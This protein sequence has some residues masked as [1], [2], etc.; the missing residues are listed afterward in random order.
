[1][2]AAGAVVWRTG[3][4]LLGVVVALVLTA[5]LRALRRECRAIGVRWVSEHLIGPPAVPRSY[6]L[7]S[8]SARCMSRSFSRFLI[9]SRLS[10]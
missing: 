8:R 7:A 4:V 6:R 2:L 10:N 9:V 5:A 1:M 3:S